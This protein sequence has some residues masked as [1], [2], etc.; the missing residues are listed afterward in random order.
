MQIF[1]DVLWK[2][3][4]KWRLLN[5]PY[6]LQSRVIHL[7]LDSVQNYLV[8]LCSLVLFHSRLFNSLEDFGFH[9]FLL[10]SIP[11]S[12]KLHCPEVF[13]ISGKFSILY[14][15]HFFS[16]VGWTAPM[17]SYSQ[18]QF[19]QT[20]CSQP[21]LKW[22][23]FLMKT[24]L[25]FLWMVV[26]LNLVTTF[27]RSCHYIFFLSV[28]GVCNS[29]GPVD[30][31]AFLLLGIANI[32]IWNICTLFS[33]YDCSCWLFY[34]FWCPSTRVSLNYVTVSLLLCTEQLFSA[35]GYFWTGSPQSPFCC[36]F[37]FFS[38]SHS[39][40][41][42]AALT[43]VFLSYFFQLPFFHMK[44]TSPFHPAFLILRA[45]ETLFS[46]CREMFYF[47]L[48]IEP[49]TEG[50]LR[51][52]LFLQLDFLPSTACCLLLLFVYSSAAGSPSIS[53]LSP[54]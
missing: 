1:A 39:C 47:V 3:L 17:L 20:K 45:V 18:H 2:V 22:G 12:C 32:C 43:S 41:G 4:V 29:H 42:T 9:H 5:T 36:P 21:L 28:L 51:Q 54:L 35:N 33:Y 8:H 19:Q 34:H 37:I 24:P 15:E 53:Y 30:G 26:L 23:C 44:P 13:Y 40:A 38:P 16:V 48:Q 50:L 49:S 14:K 31:S 52:S 6:Q 10:G 7:P 11:E 25:C 27:F 46:V